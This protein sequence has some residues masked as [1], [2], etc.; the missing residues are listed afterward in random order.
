MND[1]MTE[2]TQQVILE[3]IYIGRPTPSLTWLKNGKQ[4]TSREE[5][6]INPDGSLYLPCVSKEQAG[7]LVKD[8]KSIMFGTVCNYILKLIVL[9]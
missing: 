5:H 8:L 6:N 4:L 3:P 7:R 1:I 9:A 2:E